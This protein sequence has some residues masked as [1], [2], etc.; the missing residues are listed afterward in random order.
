M[1]HL[2]ATIQKAENKILS[3][4]QTAPLPPVQQSIG[5]Y[6]VY[7]SGLQVTTPKLQ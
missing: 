7:R 5:H 4:N 3:K 2:A 6:P 1:K